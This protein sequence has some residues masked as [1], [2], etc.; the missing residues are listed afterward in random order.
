MGLFPFRYNC[1]LWPCEKKASIFYAL[2]LGQ[3]IDYTLRLYILCNTGLAALWIDNGSLF[4]VEWLP[5]WI[6]YD[7]SS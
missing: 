7:S 3:Y 2:L 1:N 4:T 6:D 5:Y